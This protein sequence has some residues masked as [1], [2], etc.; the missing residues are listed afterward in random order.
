MA[1]ARTR[2]ARRRG[3]KAELLDLLRQMMLPCF[4]GRSSGVSHCGIP[5]F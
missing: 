1:R 4:S 2:R 3:K 5:D